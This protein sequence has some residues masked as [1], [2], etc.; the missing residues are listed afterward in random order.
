MSTLVTVAVIASGCF[1]DTTTP[2]P[3]TDLVATVVGDLNP[4]RSVEAELA[5]WGFD[6]TTVTTVWY[7]CA[8]ST[9]GC[10]QVGAKPQHV[11]LDSETGRYVRV[12][13]TG[14]AGST[15]RRQVGTAGPVE[16]GE[17]VALV[18]L[19]AGA[20]AVTSA[21]TTLDTTLLGFTTPSDMRV[22]NGGDPSA[23]A[24]QA[25]DP[26]LP[27]SLGAG[28][29]GQRTVSVQFR[30]D[31]EVSDVYTDTIGLATTGPAAT[32]LADDVRF[33]PGTGATVSV[34]AARTTTATI[35]VVQPGGATAT[36]PMTPRAGLRAESSAAVVAETTFDW[37]VPPSQTTTFDYTVQ[38]GDGSTTAIAPPTGVYTAVAA[39]DLASTARTFNTSVE[40]FNP[41]YYLSDYRKDASGIVDPAT[42][43]TAAVG[44]FTRIPG[45]YGSTGT[46][47]VTF[48]IDRYADGSVVIHDRLANAA[49]DAGVYA[50]LDDVPSVG[51]DTVGADVPVPEI[52]DWV[53]S[54][55][56][57]EPQG[58]LARYAVDGMLPVGPSQ[59]PAPGT[60]IISLER[61]GALRSVVFTATEDRQYPRAL[62]LA[63][64]SYGTGADATPPPKPANLLSWGEYSDLYA[65][66]TIEGPVVAGGGLRAGFSRPAWLTDAVVSWFANLM[67]DLVLTT[68]LCAV[69]GL[70]EIAV[71][72]NPALAAVAL[73]FLILASMADW[74]T[75]FGAYVTF[76][77]IVFA[78]VWGDPHMVTFDNLTYDFQAS[79]EFVLT[80]STTDDF[81]VHI[82]TE[83]AL[84][85]PSV[86][87][88]DGVGVRTAGGHTVVF[89][90]GDVYVDT[91]PVDDDVPVPIGSEGTLLDGKLTL[92]EGTTI[93]ADAARGF[94]KVTPAGFRQGALRGLNGS[95][96]TDPADDLA[97]RGGSTVDPAILAGPAGHAWLYD[98][99]GP[100]W[101]PEA[102]DRIFT[103][104]PVRP[105]EG[106]GTPLTLADLDPAAVAAARLLCI[107]NGWTD[108][109]G[110]ASCVFDVAAT[111]DNSLADPALR[112]GGAPALIAANSPS[113]TELSQLQLG[114]PAVGAI[115]PNGTDIWTF[116]TSGQ[117]AFFDVT[118]N[119][120]GTE[121]ECDPTTDLTWRLEGP[122][123]AVFVESPLQCIWDQG[124]HVLPAGS[125]TLIVGGNG[126]AT[127]S[128]RIETSIVPPDDTETAEL[129]DT[130]DGR[131]EAPGT[132]DVWAITSTGN[133][134]YFDIT[135]NY[136]GADPE[137]DPITD[138][139]WTLTGPGGS[140]VFGP[141]PLQC[142]YDEGPLDLPAG[143][144]LLTVAG[145][146]N[147]TGTY[148]IETSV[149]PPDDTQTF[150]LGAVLQGNI[151]APGTAD[152]WTF[153][154]TG[155]TASFDVTANY[156]GA[157]PDCD[158]ITDLSWKLT[159]PGGDVFD[160]RGLQCI[161]DEGPFALPAGTYT[162]VVRG[163]GSATGRY[164]IA[165]ATP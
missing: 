147:A 48:D 139:R 130:L 126:A 60:G 122:D 155:Q 145:N 42:G 59:E 138:L 13:V 49:V 144:Y 141:A 108:D 93:E 95:W 76:V 159:G 10:I 137:C 117:T 33:V 78:W 55:R 106:P 161:Y 2:P 163:N 52:P 5:P 63:V 62:S 125:Y 29:D 41:G 81:A 11:L 15:T 160:E 85:N 18:E 113:A 142:I 56:P 22:A 14:S 54:F 73:P 74:L 71:I 162:L 135:A 79:G 88:I 124:P 90:D 47:S 45:I 30:T 133:R 91:A 53:T 128:Y 152:R 32:A 8:T 148:S 28:P 158:P 51:L 77:N 34:T 43:E 150:S 19:A 123:G 89:D 111:G 4:G 58:G 164:T 69:V 112:P 96:N 114:N 1:P 149:V 25:F 86:A 27:W 66:A 35:T 140:E 16:P 23:A 31:G 104:L 151:Q 50:S 165:T 153:T 154:T 120:G 156:R 107:A 97:T 6:P 134:A 3:P 67:L 72:A 100:S 92:D 127:G 7:S 105:Y 38:L 44:T 40:F 129:G 118:A 39:T 24:W 20:P 121:P 65:N 116:T 101:V 82:R 70:V 119:Y 64:T 132:A 87:F 21:A 61:S 146:G 143:Q 46:N 115:T 94:V 102:A 136:R 103:M 109:R 68:A 131:I 36:Y 9:T 37:A 26:H 57:L 12:V 17:L 110:L 75:W 83:A 99:F 80:E 157:D 84:D 98:E